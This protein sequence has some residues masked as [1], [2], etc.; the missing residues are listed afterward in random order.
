MARVTEMFRRPRWS[1]GRV[2]SYRQDRVALGFHLLSLASAI[3]VLILWM[4]FSGWAAWWVL[5]PVNAAI[6]IALEQIA[7]IRSRRAVLRVEAI[8]GVEQAPITEQA[9][10]EVGIEDWINFK[11]K[12]F[13][14]RLDDY[15]IRYCDR[16]AAKF[17]TRAE[18]AEVSGDHKSAAKYLRKAERERR[19][20]QKYKR[21]IERQ[22]ERQG[23][24]F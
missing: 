9:P 14:K 16:N 24:F 2:V 1:D 12:R 20:A 13:I 21:G 7:K 6:N 11:N 17:M 10:V 5:I 15:V 3:T 8:S 22:D 4:V 18:T 23:R 19:Q